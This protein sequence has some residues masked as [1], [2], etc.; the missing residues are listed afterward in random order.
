MK[1]LPLILAGPILRRVEP[2]LVAVWVAVK[3]SCKVKLTVYQGI[4]KVSKLSKAVP[5]A[6]AE[7]D[8]IRIGDQLHIL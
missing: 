8:T 1:E 4:G 7:A 3:E 6:E 5:V 2:K